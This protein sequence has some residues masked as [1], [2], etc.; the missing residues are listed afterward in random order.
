MKKIYVKPEMG[1]SIIEVQ[2]ILAGSLDPDS[3]ETGT[4]TSG[5]GANSDDIGSNEG[6]F[7]WD[8]ED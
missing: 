4:G 6:G 7:L 2:T 5:G 1:V 8:D 3:E